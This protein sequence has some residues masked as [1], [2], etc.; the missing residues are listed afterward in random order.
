MCRAFCRQE[1][2]QGTARDSSR[3]ILPLARR[4]AARLLL[5]QFPDLLLVEASAALGGRI[6]QVGIQAKSA[7][8]IIS[9]ELPICAL[10]VLSL[11]SVAAQTS[12]WPQSTAEVTHMIQLLSFELDRSPP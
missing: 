3:T 1:A 5:P 4:Y 6:K 12:F 10:H 2:V 7:V 8:L 9:N 11:R